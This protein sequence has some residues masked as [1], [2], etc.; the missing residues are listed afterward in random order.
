MSSARGKELRHWFDYYVTPQSEIEKF[1]RSSCFDF[2]TA[3]IL[4][5]A[6]GG[7]ESH[8][9]SYPAVIKKVF[10]KGIDTIDIRQDSKAAVKADYLLTDCRNKY[11]IIITNPPWCLA[12]E[13][14]KKAIDDVKENGV[15]IMLLRLN[16]LGSKDRNEWLK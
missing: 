16:F 6:A 2:V 15:V 11:D 3:D 13:F 7:D 5:P 14:I 12:M 10:G 1:L 4:D 8:E 9:M